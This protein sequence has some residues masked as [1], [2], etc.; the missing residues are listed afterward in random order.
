MV[1]VEKVKKNI[2]A[3]SD[4]SKL[5]KPE[6]VEFLEAYNREWKENLG[7]YMPPMGT[8][9]SDALKMELPD[10]IINNYKKNQLTEL[11]VLVYDSFKGAK[12]VIDERTPKIIRIL[13]G[14]KYLALLVAKLYLTFKGV[15]I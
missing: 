14:L 13:K 11:M 4:W 10:Y 7:K 9:K 12:T 5:T 3:W 8:R 2:K 1:T 15:K 6:K